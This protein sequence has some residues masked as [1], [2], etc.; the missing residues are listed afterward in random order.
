M[1]PTS[2]FLAQNKGT[3]ITLVV[4]VVVAV[5]AWLVY[6]F[7]VSFSIVS[8]SPA[9]NRMAVTQPII[10]IDFTKDI[11]TDNLD[12]TL[13][14]EGAISSIEPKGKSVII[15]LYD[16]LEAETE[17]TLTIHSI[18][19]VN[20]SVI[21]D[22]TH[23]FTPSDD[24]SLLTKEARDIILFRQNQKPAAMQDEAFNKTPITGDDFV[25]KSYL[26]AAP[27]DQAVVRLEVTIYLYRSL[28]EEL[29]GY[30][31]AVNT[32]NAKANQA[33]KDAGLDIEK[34][35]VEY[36]VQNS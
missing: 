18:E 34:Y 26:D 33:I 15:N 32:V 27:N 14:P 22:Y 5:A 35:D 23:T 36:K 28:I 31:S 24:L 10:Q 7:L 20:G 19:S 9:A 30:E 2:S 3:I 25:V 29:G 16:V 11:S 13:S 8:I 21:K 17:Y 12:I 6:F 4:A 1:Q